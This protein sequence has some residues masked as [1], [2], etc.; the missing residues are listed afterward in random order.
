MTQGVQPP[1]DYDANAL[2]EEGA[3]EIARSRKKRFKQIAV[4][5]GVFVF[6]ILLFIALTAKPKGTIQYGICKVFLEKQT[7]YPDTLHITNVTQFSSSVRIRYGVIDPFGMYQQN[8]IECSFRADPQ[9]GAAI[10]QIEMDNRLIDQKKIALF[11]K[12]LGSILENP[13]D[14][15]LP[16]PFSD[17]LRGLKPD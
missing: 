12:T 11:N 10:D 9:F 5:L 13:P 4:G 16:P 8:M 3:E 7:R 6:L 2:H 15:T 1:Q 17:N 14:L